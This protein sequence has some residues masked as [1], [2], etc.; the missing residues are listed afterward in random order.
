M[1][2]PYWIKLYHKMMHDPQVATLSDRLWRRWVECILYSADTDNDGNLGDVSDMAFY[3]RLK[4]VELDKDLDKLGEVELLEKT[5]EGWII[6][7]FKRYQYSSSSDRVRK[8]R[9]KKKEDVDRQK[10]LEDLEE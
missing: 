1:A 10:Y 7:N 5:D 2:S 9:A 8:H 3:L 4:K 6:P